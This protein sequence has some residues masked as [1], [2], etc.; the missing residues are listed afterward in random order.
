MR[1]AL[2]SFLEPMEDILSF[3]DLLPMV[4]ALQEDKAVPNRSTW[5]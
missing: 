2:G 5:G 3:V 1:T 4:V